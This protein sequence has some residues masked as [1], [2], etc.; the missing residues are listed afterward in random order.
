MQKQ[1]LKSAGL[2][3]D[4]SIEEMV[5]NIKKIKVGDDTIDDVVRLMGNPVW[6]G[7]FKGNKILAF[8]MD[9]SVRVWFDNS[10]HTLGVEVSKQS[11]NGS[12]SVYVKGIPIGGD[13][14]STVGATNSIDHLPVKYAAPENPT[15]GQYYF[16]TTDKHAY[17]WS[18][19]EWLQLDNPKAQLTP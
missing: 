7:N 8:S 18:G 12:E 3:T 11:K 14:P 1:A 15:E 16:N 13:V 9:P 19:T 2:L 17:L 5:I 4:Q 6:Q 10:G